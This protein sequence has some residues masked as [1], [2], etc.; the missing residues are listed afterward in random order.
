MFN[1]RYGRYYSQHFLL[2]D[3]TLNPSDEQ[4]R[5]LAQLTLDRH[6]NV[7]VGKYL[8]NF[9]IRK[10]IIPLFKMAPNLGLF[11]NFLTQK[12]PLLKTVFV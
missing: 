9:R 7:F 5:K 6:K 1:L 3:P 10:I 4:A 12:S 2:A 8:E 11:A